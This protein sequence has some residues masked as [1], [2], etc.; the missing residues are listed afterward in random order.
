MRPAASRKV[1]TL[2]LVFGGASNLPARIVDRGRACLRQRRR[3]QQRQ[4]NDDGSHV[5]NLIRRLDRSNRKNGTEIMYQFQMV[6]VT[7]VLVLGCI[8]AMPQEH[9]PMGSEHA[10]H[11]HPFDNAEKWSAEF[12]DPARDQWQKPHEII[13][14]LSLRP[15]DVVADIG[16]G[17]GYLSVR[18]A[19]HLTE[20]TVYAVDAE[21]NMVQHLAERAKASGIANL[22][23]ILAD[24]TSA[25]LPEKVDIG[26]LLDV[27]HHIS[28]R[29]DYFKRL[30]DSLKPGGRVAIIDFR[31][32][33]PVGAPKEMRIPAD[34]IKAEMSAAGYRL[35]STYDFLPYQNF[36]VF[37]KDN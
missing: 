10:G 5:L 18:L 4:C 20:G 15:T 6:V 37:Q 11:N 2:L 24:A 28:N 1:V 16:A 7:C 34:Q 31:P 22:R 3:R 25:N 27:Y 21:K 33:S 36:L 8:P 29:Q 35:A 17:T 13:T 9:P 23:P 19:R 32:D 12:D 14:A 30:A 26:I